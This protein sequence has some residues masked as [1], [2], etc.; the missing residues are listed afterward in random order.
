MYKWSMDMDNSVAVACGIGGGMGGEQG[1][2]G[3]SGKL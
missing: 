1:G 3:E 2:G